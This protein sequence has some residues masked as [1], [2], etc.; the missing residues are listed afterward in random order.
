VSE[1]IYQ[2]LPRFVPPCG[3]QED[4]GAHTDE[5]EGWLR[6]QQASGQTIDLRPENTLFV[7]D[8]HSLNVSSVS[9]ITNC[10]VRAWL[11]EPPTNSCKE[12]SRVKASEYSL[13]PTL[14]GDNV[15]TSHSSGRRR[16]LPSHGRETQRSKYMCQFRMCLT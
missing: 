6:T 12:K 5:R 3:T 14:A 2:A 9:S 13:T 15:G 16:H 8:H 1:P 10:G 4:D 7:F 11:A